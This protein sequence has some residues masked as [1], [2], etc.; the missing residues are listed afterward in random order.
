MMVYQANLFSKGLTNVESVRE[1]KARLESS[2]PLPDL[3][4]FDWETIAVSVSGGKDSQA[5]ANLAFERFG[6]E[7]VK[8]VHAMVELPDT[9]PEQLLWETQQNIEHLKY[10][11]EVWQIPIERVMVFNPNR[12]PKYKPKEMLD[13]TEE[14]FLQML[15]ES[16]MQGLTQIVLNNNYMPGSG[17]AY[18]TESK[19][20]ALERWARQHDKSKLLQVWGQRA[21]EGVRRAKMPEYG[22]TEY[23]GY[24]WRAVHKWTEKQVIDYLTIQLKQK[25]NP[26]YTLPE[27]I[28][29]ARGGNCMFC[30][31]QRK[32]ELRKSVKCFPQQAL[33]F[34]EK[35]EKTVGQRR[36]YSVADAIRDAALEQELPGIFQ[37]QDEI[38]E[39]FP[40][41]VCGAVD[42]DYGCGS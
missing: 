30:I 22:H 21:E 42:F 20:L 5:C 29:G 2:F 18:C 7:R 38:E 15:K 3:D 12:T 40:R 10:L 9:P 28:R 37:E 24:V 27:N 14:E 32:Y 17:M 26:V 19:S 31:N 4:S 16:P 25:I 8:L 13:A 11:E 39:A 1:R 6:K 23:G 36:D 34:V 35:I 33:N 41:R